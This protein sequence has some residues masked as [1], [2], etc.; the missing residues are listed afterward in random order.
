MPIATLLQ[1]VGKETAGEDP[2]ASRKAIRGIVGNRS[3]LPRARIDSVLVGLERLA[4]ADNEQVRWAAVEML[5]DFGRSHSSFQALP[6][7]YARLARIYA[8]SRDPLV[9]ATIVG[10]LPELDER[11]LALPFLTSLASAPADRQ[12][13]SGATDEAIHA[14]ARMG[15]PGMVVLRRLYEQGELRGVQDVG[16]NVFLSNTARSRGWGPRGRSTPR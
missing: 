15:D 4:S 8:S 11:A 14:L 9:R 10:E 12:P 3:R 5:A 7:T 6:G 2:Y 13:F 16:T 1:R